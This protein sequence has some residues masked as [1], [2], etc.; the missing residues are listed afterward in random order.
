METRSRRDLT[1][2]PDDT[3]FQTYNKFNYADKQYITNNTYEYQVIEKKEEINEDN[4]TEEQNGKE[5]EEIAEL[6]NVAETRYPF[7]GRVHQNKK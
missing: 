3:R 7:I 6:S 2:I 4:G 5:M 1:S